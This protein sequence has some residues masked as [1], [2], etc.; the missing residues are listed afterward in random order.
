MEGII[1]LSKKEAHRAR[2]MEQVVSGV[3]TVK[4]ASELLGLSYRQAKRIKRRYVFAGI[5]GLVHGNRGREPTNAIDPS[6]KG[7]VLQLHEDIYSGLNDTHFTEFLKE[8]EGIVLCRES[9]RQILR[10]SGRGAKQKRRPPR[11]HAR[12][13][14]KEVRGVMAQWDGSPHRWFGKERPPCCLMAAVDDAEGDILGALFVPAESSEAYLCRPT[15][16]VTVASFA[17]TT[18]GALMNS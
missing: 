12:R 16:T 10:S 17:T 14:R 18:T 5:A 9:V 15:T 7:R 8:R 13:P 11:H 2:V 3:I 6:V 4:K 1:V